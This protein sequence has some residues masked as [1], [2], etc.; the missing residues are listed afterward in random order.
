MQL[1]VQ[2]ET[3]KCLAALVIVGKV[4]TK[5]P[6][7]S[8]TLTLTPIVLKVK[9]NKVSG[10][11]GLMLRLNLTFDQYVLLLSDLFILVSG[12]NVLQKKGWFVPFSIILIKALV[13]SECLLP[14]SYL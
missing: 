7:L 9:F 3:P 6:F 8:K 11:L 12:D 14:I 10:V 1:I 5:L 4:S 13:L 2:F